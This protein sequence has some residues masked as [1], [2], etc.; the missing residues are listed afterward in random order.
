MK[1][2]KT[3]KRQIIYHT[4]EKMGHAT[5]AEV[6]EFLSSHGVRIPTATLYRNILVLSKDGE[7]REVEMSGKTVYEIVARPH[8]YHFHCEEC[9][10]IIDIPED[11]IQVTLS[12]ELLAKFAS[13]SSLDILLH[14]TC[15]NCEKKMK[16]R[17]TEKGEQNEI[18]M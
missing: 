10:E 8:H 13:I 9:G 5:L 4:I 3:E 16:I 15:S 14:G 18:Q 17:K 11:E 12:K 6:N 2:R 1:R 7:I